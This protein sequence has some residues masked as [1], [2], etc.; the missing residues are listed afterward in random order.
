MSNFVHSWQS[1]PP[2]ILVLLK[3]VIRFDED[4]ARGPLKQTPEIPLNSG[5]VTM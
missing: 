2:I 3:L 5:V 4:P 1:D